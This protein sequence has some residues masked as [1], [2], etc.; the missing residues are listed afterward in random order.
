MI[1]WPKSSVGSS[2]MSNG[3][4]TPLMSGVA[5]CLFDWNPL[6]SIKK[7]KIS[8]K[9]EIESFDSMVVGNLKSK[10]GCNICGVE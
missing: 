8:S 2:R 6:R 1:A 10:K 5:N 9:E 3:N 7:M 4:K